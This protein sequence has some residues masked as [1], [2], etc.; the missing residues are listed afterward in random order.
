MV[1]FLKIFTC[2]NHQEWQTQHLVHVYKLQKA[3]YGL[4]QAPRV[5][6]DRFSTFLLKHG[7]FYSLSD[8]SL[9]ILHSDYCSLI[10]LLYVDEMITG[11]TPTLISNFILLLSTRF[12]TKDL[13]PI[14]HFL[15]MEITPATNDLHLVTL[16][17]DNT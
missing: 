13:G 5:W 1:Q 10:L 14:H 6:F 9:F 4:K 16:C 12:A 3:L 8:P 2:N 15:G 17:I 11:S 7:F